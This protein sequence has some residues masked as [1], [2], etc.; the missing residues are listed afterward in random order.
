MIHAG[1]S[2]AA[3]YGFGI[4]STF[5]S[6][7]GKSFLIG[8]LLVATMFLAM[9]NQGGGAIDPTTGLPLGSSKGRAAIDPLTG[10][11]VRGA[12]MGGGMAGGV[13]GMG[14][15]MPFFFDK[16]QQWHVAEF[17]LADVKAGKT[18]GYELTGHQRMVNNVQY[19]TGR[20][21]IR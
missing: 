18:T 21:R 10:L 16:R 1:N 9:A 19:W 7:D 14:G 13:P 15:G 4:M 20:T 12:G 5:K 3:M 17:S 6:I 2:V 11:P 8:G